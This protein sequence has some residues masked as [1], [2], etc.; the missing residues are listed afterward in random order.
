[1]TSPIEA[2]YI[3]SGALT[4]AQNLYVTT[5][6][7]NVLYTT[8][9]TANFSFNIASTSG[10]TLN[11]LMSVGQTLTVTIQATMGSTAYYMT[12]VSIDGTAL[13]T[14]TNLWWQ[15]GSA[16][17]AGNPSGIDVYSFSITKTAAS[18]YTVLGSQ[19]KF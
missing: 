2:T 8:A 5:N 13:V 3:V 16:P 17:T 12:A 6:S 1:M 14:N 18:T 19:V 9:A 11:S 7:A 4:G 10:A 15:G